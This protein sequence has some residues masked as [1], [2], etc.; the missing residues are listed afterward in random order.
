M[1]NSR[2]GDEGMRGL[3]VIDGNIYNYM[4]KLY[5]V[6]VLNLLFIIASLPIITIGAALTALYDVT[7][8]MQVGI[9]KEMT[10]SFVK[11]FRK[12]GMQATKIWFA[13]LSFIAI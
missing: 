5:E 1:A 12:N 3:F 4:L 9:E 8:K 10:R 13:F 6:M 11:S 7:L 2:Q